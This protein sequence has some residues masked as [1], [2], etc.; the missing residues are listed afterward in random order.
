LNP[1]IKPQPEPRP[2]QDIKP[3]TANTE[4]VNNIPVQ[5]PVSKVFKPSSSEAQP[6]SNDR[7]FDHILKDVNNS[8]KQ[9]GKPAAVKENKPPAKEASQSTR[10]ILATA[11]ACLVALML[12]AAA[13]MAY[14]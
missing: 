10:P 3:Q 12:I 4:V 11:A 14:R 8:V 2:V 7:E 5:S 9:A 13:V 1:P 6:P